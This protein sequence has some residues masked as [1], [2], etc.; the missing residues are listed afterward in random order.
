[1]FATTQL[2]TL[3]GIGALALASSCVFAAPVS[4][5]NASGSNSVISWSNGQSDK[6]LFGDPTVN[7]S[8]FLFF[9]SNFEAEASNGSA[10][11]TSDRLSFKLTAAEGKEIQKVTIKELGDWS[12]LGGGA[13][14]A[15]GTLYITRLNSPGFGTVWTDTLDVIYNDIENSTVINS[16]AR[17]NG[18]GSG[19][20]DGTFTIDLPA[21]VTSVQVVL[22]NVLQASS[23]AGGSAFIQKK[24]LGDPGNGDP[25][26]QIDVV[27]PEPTT[28][29][30]L[31]VGAAGLLRRRRNCTSN[32]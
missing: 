5:T 9:P 10:K 14:K 15:F 20:W 8:T 11:T 30:L 2:A 12:I 19:T 17:P 22:N 7:G 16:P 21:G 6:G 29:G 13:V 27:I 31:F 32:N 25:Q 26:F 28:L 24:F 23:T 1:M 3:G 4:W 18:E